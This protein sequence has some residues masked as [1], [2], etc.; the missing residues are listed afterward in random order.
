MEDFYLARQ[1][2]YDR[3]LNVFAYELLFRDDQQKTA[4]ILDGNSATSQ[5]IINAFLHIGLDKIVGDK[6]AFIN[7][8]HDML[9]HEDTL[10]LPK[11]HVVLEVLEDIP[12]TPTVVGAVQNLID[13]GFCVA[14]DDFMYNDE[15]RPLVDLAQ[16]IKIDI[17]PLSSFQIREQVNLLR[18]DGRKLL[19]E[20]VETIEQYQL[21]RS[22]GFDYFQGYFVAQ[23]H[24]I[25]G[26]RPPANRLMILHLL[27]KLQNPNVE[28]DEI[29][30]VISKDLSLSYRVLRTINSSLFNL[31]TKVESIRTA[32]Q[33]IGLKQLKHLVSVIALANFDD[34][35]SELVML[36]LIRAK[37]SELICKA[38]NQSDPEVAFTAGLFSMLEAMLDYPMEDILKELPLSDELSSALLNHE[39]NIGA[40]LDMVESYEKGDWDQIKLPE[41]TSIDITQLYLESITWAEESLKNLGS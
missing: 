4:N 28:I 39:G 13:N 18:G 16:I 40:I 3:E 32:I 17:L 30:D 31:P 36:S 15:L 38:L 33:F 19:A 24:I 10:Q 37:F 26:Q 21:C 27:G 9:V 34:K 8:P 7:L 1:A 35:P 41:N 22:L 23:P 20:K 11:E 12:P 14:L 6:R 25:A 5:V 2:I 29:E